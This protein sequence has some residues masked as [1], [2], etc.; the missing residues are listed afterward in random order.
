MHSIERTGCNESLS[1][2]ISI[3]DVPNLNQLDL[4][5]DFRNM[6]S[7][8]M[9]SMNWFDHAIVDASLFHD[10]EF[11][12]FDKVICSVDEFNTVSNSIKELV[13]G[14]VCLNEMKEISFS[15]F[16][17]LETLNVGCRSLQKVECVIIESIPVMID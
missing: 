8:E 15:R 6:Q 1:T 10:V 16:M 17:E 12:R 2:L 11:Q 7:V 13:I 9:E 14:N 5:S 3:V 4:Q